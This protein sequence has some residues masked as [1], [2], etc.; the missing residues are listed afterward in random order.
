[1][2]D[3]AA[4]SRRQRRQHDGMRLAQILALQQSAD[5]RAFVRM[6]GGQFI[7]PHQ[8]LGHLALFRDQQQM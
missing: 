2:I 6:R 1:M 7:G 5:L 3:L 8:N 4:L